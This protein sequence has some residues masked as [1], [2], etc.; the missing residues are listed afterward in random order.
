[1]RI[2]CWLGVYSRPQGPVKY[3]DVNRYRIVALTFE[4]E[5]VG[6]TPMNRDETLPYGSF[7]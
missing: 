2:V 6:D 3:M 7:A 4:A 1:M 5:P